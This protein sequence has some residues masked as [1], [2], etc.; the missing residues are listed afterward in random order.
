MDG[1]LI[2]CSLPRVLMLGFPTVG[3]IGNANARSHAC[4][5]GPNANEPKLKILTENI[6]T[7]PRP[8]A[9]VILEGMAAMCKAV[10]HPMFWGGAPV[11]QPLK[12]LIGH[13]GSSELA[14]AALQGSAESEE[15]QHLMSLL[16]AVSEKI[17]MA[18][19]ELIAFFF[20]P[21]ADLRGAEEPCM[22]VRSVATN[23]AC[24]AWAL[25][26]LACRS[27]AA[28]T[29]PV[30]CAASCCSTSAAVRRPHRSRPRLRCWS[31]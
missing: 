7:L 4:V 23:G 9:L 18:E 10:R 13:F 24:F 3:S 14:V 22:V 21:P 12:H 29:L 1:D 25:R 20:T 15:V 26:S 17:R 11:Q 8:M 16:S 6:A 30:V 19:S 31:G 28:N 5:P 2:A 27:A